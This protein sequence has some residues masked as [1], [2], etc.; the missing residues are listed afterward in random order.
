MTTIQPTD[1]FLYHESAISHRF[2]H[3]LTYMQ[4]DIL[5]ET[6]FVHFPRTHF[7]NILLVIHVNDLNTPA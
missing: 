7:L 5:R 4:A 2:D 1:R 3:S 6:I